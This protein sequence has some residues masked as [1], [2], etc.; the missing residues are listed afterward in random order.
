[1]EKKNTS[2]SVIYILLI[3]LLVSIIGTT[4]FLTARIGG[5]ITSTFGPVQAVNQA[6][7]TQVSQLLN[8]TP[9]VI[10]DP[11]TIIRE[12]QSLARLETIQYTVEKVITAE[13][14]QGVFGPLF[15]DKLLFVAHGISIAGVDLSQLETED[16]R[17]EDGKLYVTM[18]EAEVFV[19]TLNNDESYVYDRTTGLLRKGDPQLETE[20][21]QVAEQEILNAALEDGILEQAQIN[22]EIFLERLLNDLGYSYVVFE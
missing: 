1:M 5:V 15:G 7:S 19:T 13:V 18:P 11:I 22:A 9:T 3:V 17:M 20:A 21:R 2:L 6:L 4:I 12:V 10:P 16:L 14:N 8:P